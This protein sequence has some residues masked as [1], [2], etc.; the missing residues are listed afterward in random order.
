MRAL[1]AASLLLSGA[2]AGAA[3]RISCPEPVHDFGTMDGGRHAEN[4]FVIRNDGDETLKI[5]RVRACCGATAKMS[6]KIIEPGTNA[7][8]FV[9]LSLRGRRGKQRKS[10]YIASNDPRQPYFQVRMV[11]TAVTRVDVVPRAVSFGRVG[12]EDCL[13]NVVRIVCQS[14]WVFSVTNAVSSEGRFAVRVTSPDPR[15]HE[16]AVSTVPPL[17]P[18]VTKGTVVL[19]TDNPRCPKVII[20]VS[21]TVSSDIMVV[22]REILLTGSED[23]GP[24]TRY[25]AVRSRTGRPFKVLKV[26]TPD[27]GIEPVVSPLGRA[28]HRCELRNVIPFEGL[29]GRHV[30]FVTDSEAASRIAVPI[31]IVKP[32]KGS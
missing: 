6:S 2:L 9:K 11:G 21:A 29:A 8:F 32:R 27:D 31:R 18:G 26:E 19:L 17:L 7:T 15:R 10:F 24:V 16:V 12:S 13:T 28:G 5:G 20:P 14:D 30:T 3:P 4:A 22:P 25:V 23:S 1:A